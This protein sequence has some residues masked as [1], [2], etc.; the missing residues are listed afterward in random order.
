[1]NR[2]YRV[3][4]DAVALRGVLNLHRDLDR[5]NVEKDLGSR[6]GESQFLDRDGRDDYMTGG[7]EGSCRGLMPL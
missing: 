5:S 4:S 7:L 6:R 2:G 3:D 1:M